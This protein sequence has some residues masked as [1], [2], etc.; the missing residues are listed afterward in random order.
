M[1]LEFILMLLKVLKDLIYLAL[2]NLGGDLPLPVLVILE[3]LLSCDS[4]QL[5]I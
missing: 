4:H 5:I 3:K 1:L 2:S